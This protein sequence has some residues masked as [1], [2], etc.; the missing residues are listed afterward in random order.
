MNKHGD[1]AGGILILRPGVALDYESGTWE[2][3]EK[4]C[5]RCGCMKISRRIFTCIRCGGSATFSPKHP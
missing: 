3:L 4:S 1:T 2:Q 5:R